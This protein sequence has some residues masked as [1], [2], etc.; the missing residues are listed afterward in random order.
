MSFLDKFFASAF[1]LVALFLILT[2]GRELNQILTGFAQSSSQIF[3]TL[4]ARG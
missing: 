3:K 2:N 1:A 4:Q